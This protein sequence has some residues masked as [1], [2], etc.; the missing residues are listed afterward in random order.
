MALEDVAD[1]VRHSVSS[2]FPSDVPPLH[3]LHLLRRALNLHYMQ[4]LSTANTE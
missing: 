4:D 3:A 1:G 2:Q